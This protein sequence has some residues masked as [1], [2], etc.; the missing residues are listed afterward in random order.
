MGSTPRASSPRSRRR[1]KPLASC[2]SS[3]CSMAASK[4]RPPQMPRGEAPAPPPPPAKIRAGMG[5]I[6][7]DFVEVW[8]DEDQAR[9]TGLL[10]ILREDGTADAKAVPALDAAA[11][12]EIY[13]GM[14]RIRIVDERLM[15]LQRQG[16]I[17]FYAEARG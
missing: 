10:S 4:S 8:S 5:D 17:G 6:E 13:R 16:R 12:R 3:R 2:S 11:L 15:A 14:V 9:A 7:S 1:W